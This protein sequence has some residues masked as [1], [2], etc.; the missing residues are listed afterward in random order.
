MNI[1]RIAISLLLLVAIFA[2]GA[3]SGVNGECSLCKGGSPTAQQDVL[4]NEWAVFLGKENA[5]TEVITSAGGLVNPRYNR[6]NNPSLQAKKT[7]ELTTKQAGD[8]DSSSV[9]AALPSKTVSDAAIKRSFGFA[10]MLASFDSI[11][12]SDIILDISPNATEY[13]PGA[14]NIPY[15]QFVEA[16][17]ILKSVSQLAAILGD[18]GISQNDAVKIAGECQPCGGGPSAAGFGYVVMKYLGHKDVKMLDGSI[19]D[20]VA[21]G[22]PTM[23]KPVVLPPQDYIASIDADLMATYEFVQSGTPQIIDARTSQ[24]FDAG[25]IPGAINIP[26]SRVLDAKR[27]KDESDLKELFSS[28]AMDK[29]VIVYTNTGVKASMVWF[30]LGLL[31]Y[32]A[33]IYTWQNWVANSPRLDIDLQEAYAKPNPAMIGD[34]VQITALFEEINNSSSRQK[35]KQNASETVLTI[36]GCATCGFGSPQGYAD[37]SSTDGTVK[38][39][40]TSQAQRTAA[41][42]VFT[43]SSQLLS[44]SGN[45]VSRVVMKR[46][47]SDGDEFVGIWN[48]NVAAGT[49]RVDVVATLGEVTKTF[50]D[51][52]KI[53]VVSTSKYKNLGEE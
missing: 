8:Q 35:A 5:T 43:V 16:G 7:N 9:R 10:N 28:I 44:P 52:L 39:G 4:N 29:P 27:I 51:A 37:L 50:P 21:E 36:K 45:T 11:N 48:A 47:K 19:D 2:G 34:V 26:Y 24:E 23:A 25:A 31:G 14:I 22:R 40:S 20:W 49:Y 42:K 1:S 17:G 38:I 46:I 3:V 18:A 53:K 15:T 30:A 6:A 33:R 41:E 12:D 13:I 32:D